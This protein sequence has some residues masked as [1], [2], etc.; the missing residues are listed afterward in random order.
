MGDEKTQLTLASITAAIVIVIAL[1]AMPGG[2]NTGST[3]QG[4]PTTSSKTDSTRSAGTDDPS[5]TD[6]GALAGRSSSTVSLPD[7]DVRTGRPSDPPI[8]ASEIKVGVTYTEDPGQANAA[9][10]FAIAQI[11]QRRGWEALISQINRD[12]AFGRKVVPVWY[13][14]TEEEFASKGDERVAQ[15]AC[16]RFTQDNKVFMVWVGTI[17]LDDALFACLTKAEIPSIVFGTGASY[18]KTFEK[19][20][21]LV[22]PVSAGMDRM[23]AFYVDQLDEARFF[24]V[25]KNNQAP[26]TPQKPADGKP[27]IGLIR[28]DEPS[29]KAGAVALKKRLA[30]RGLA[31]CNG[32]EFEIAFSPDS[33]PEQLDD[34]TE[35]NAAIQS[36][37]SRNCTHML[38]LGHA[39]Q[40]LPTFFIDGA[41][42]QQYRPRIGFGPLDSPAF[43]RDFL[44]PSS[45][46][47]FRE[48]LL[49]TWDPNEVGERT[50]GFKRCKKVF[51]DAGETFEGDEAAEK[52]TMMLAYCD[53]AWYYTAAAT[54]AGRNINVDSWMNG[55]H[56]MTAAPSAGAYVMQTKRGRHDGIGAIRIGQWAD[57]CNCFKPATGVI[58]V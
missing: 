47:Q 44:G 33:V 35:I 23:A 30:A 53:T 56:T 39:A 24:S 13:S 42:R 22:E 43:V 58:P 50:D 2:D 49:V 17:G 18:S 25:F 37:K 5:P 3:S 52:E 41:E 9:A 38:F 19:F 20:P 46:P 32:C 4:A 14:Q 40:R 26:Y 15:E 8:T 36:C 51:E 48:S 11:D 21:Y 10:G 6:G 31:L 29:F 7:A 34:A 54:A 45:Y 28:Y 27:R 1:V 55:V 57:G 12:P 16:A